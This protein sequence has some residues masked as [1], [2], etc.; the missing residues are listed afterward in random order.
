MP[1]D[2]AQPAGGEHGN[3][4]QVAMHLPVILVEDVGAVASDRLVDGQLI[5]RM[6]GERDQVVYTL[7]E[8][9]TIRSWCGR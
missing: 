7:F 4:R 5:E 6:V 1:E 9:P 8:S 3:V 2:A